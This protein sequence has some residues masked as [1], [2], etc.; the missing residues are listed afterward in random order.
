MAMAIAPSVMRLN[1][2]PIR[3]IASIEDENPVIFLEHELLY[4]S[5]GEVPEDPDFLPEPVA[6]VSCTCAS[7]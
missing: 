2:C 3:Y 7:R 6:R 5:K 4:N 1:V